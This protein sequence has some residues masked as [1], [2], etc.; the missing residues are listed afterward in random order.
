MTPL[1][2]IAM[3]FVIILVDASFSG[4]DGVPDPLGWALVIAGLMPLRSVLDNASA[5][6]LLAATCL[7]VSLATYPPQV[8]ERLNESGGWALSLP[9]LAFSFVLCGALAPVAGWLAGRLRVLRWVF[10][11]LAVGPILVLGGGMEILGD[12]LALLIVG[13][14]IYLVYL[15][16]QASGQVPS[17]ASDQSSGA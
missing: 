4:Y 12:P 2:K 7:V 6:V 9:Q 1:Q 16:F 10:V 17:T 8:T 5:L 3:G 14:N 11:V 13:A 15:L